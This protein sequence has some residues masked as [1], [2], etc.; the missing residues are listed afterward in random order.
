MGVRGVQEAN[1]LPEG[2]KRERV[3]PQ[4][5]LSAHKPRLSNS[6]PP[7]AEGID[8]SAPFV[9]Y[10][11]Y[12]FPPPGHPV[13]YPANQPAPDPRFF[14][15]VFEDQEEA[16][17][18]RAD[19][20][21]RRRV[22]LRHT[23]EAAPPVPYKK[24]SHSRTPLVAPPR[25]G[26]PRK[27]PLSPN[28]VASD[29]AATAPPSPPRAQKRA[30]G[31]DMPPATGAQHVDLT[32]RHEQLTDWHLSAEPTGN[33]GLVTLPT[34]L[35]PLPS[36]PLMPLLPAIQPAEKRRNCELRVAGERRSSHPIDEKKRHGAAGATPPASLI[37]SPA[38]N[39]KSPKGIE[40]RSTV[41]PS[42]VH[43]RE[44]VQGMP[45][46]KS[47]GPMRKTPRSTVMAVSN[48]LTSR[49]PEEYEAF[50]NG[51]RDEP[52]VPRD[53]VLP[54]SAALSRDG[55]RFSAGSK[56]DFPANIGHGSGGSSVVRGNTTISKEGV[57]ATSIRSRPSVVH[58]DIPPAAK[59]SSFHPVRQAAMMNM[60]MFAGSCDGD[61]PVNPHGTDVAMDLQKTIDDLRAEQ[62]SNW[63]KELQELRGIAAERLRQSSALARGLRVRLDISFR[64]RLGDRI[65]RASM[66]TKRLARQIID[67][68]DVDQRWSLDTIVLDDVALLNV[69]KLDD[70]QLM[71]L[72]LL[73]EMEAAPTTKYAKRRTLDRSLVRRISTVRRELERLASGCSADEVRPVPYFRRTSA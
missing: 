24:R 52:D 70:L 31:A 60:A 59:G 18:L 7:E 12:P 30:R 39:M 46:G 47:P 58:T 51:F 34:A 67:T 10:R 72:S 44:P 33:A 36:P 43:R 32:R 56:H 20:A 69:H 40:R 49:S 25:R 64:Q 45:S 6:P 5:S 29:T 1:I 22:L 21:L 13:A 54:P 14:T 2:V 63:Q 16:S 27:R 66:E 3:K 17:S 48:L 4:L 19:L 71:T 23:V 28:A 26:R 38:L 57:G 68:V 55:R 35:P 15:S 50:N 42:G 73:L 53:L 61:G 11:A 9:E 37:S 65:A 41:S 8:S 62:R